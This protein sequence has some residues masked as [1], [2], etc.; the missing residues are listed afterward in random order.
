M[1][2]SE[3]VHFDVLEAPLPRAGHPVRRGAGH[4]VVPSLDIANGSSRARPAEDL[5]RPPLSY[6]YQ[7]VKYGAEFCQPVR[8]LE[9]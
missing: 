1:F 7:V 3:E 5:A 9:E 8:Y 2:E 6:D 4:Q